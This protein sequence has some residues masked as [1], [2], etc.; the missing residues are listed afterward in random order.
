MMVFLYMSGFLLMMNWY[1]GPDDAETF[2]MELSGFL[3]EY[4]MLIYSFH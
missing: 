1:V 4:G 2:Q 3:R